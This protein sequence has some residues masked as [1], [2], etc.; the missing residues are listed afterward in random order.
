MPD[1][2]KPG[3]VPSPKMTTSPDAKTTSSAAVAKTAASTSPQTPPKPSPPV[4][5]VEQSDRCDDALA[6]VAMLCR[7]PLDKVT[8]MAHGLGYPKVGPAYVTDDMLVA[9]VMK[10]GNWVAKSYKD[11]THF[12]ALPPI[13]ILYVDYSEVL[14]VGRTVLWLRPPAPSD[15]VKLST[16]AAVRP[17]QAPVQ[18][19]R[20]NRVE[21][22]QGFVMDPAYWI[23]PEQQILTGVSIMHFAPGWFMELTQG[24]A[25]K[26]GK[27]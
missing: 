9:F 26:T 11:F 10:A 17:G 21:L 14:D 3:D 7:M 23:K 6:C 4:S 16:K 15:A 5:R 25:S 27:S 18:L 12:D 8:E 22:G 20:G 2:S 24:P 1:D 19:V 13:A